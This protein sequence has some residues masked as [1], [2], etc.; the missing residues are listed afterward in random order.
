ME[1]RG[2]ERNESTT[3]RQ[4]KWSVNSPPI[5]GPITEAMPYME[6]KIALTVYHKHHART[7]Q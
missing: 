1:H 6:F 4:D 3:H 7:S 2:C 5:K